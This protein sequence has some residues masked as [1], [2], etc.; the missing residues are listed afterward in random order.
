M[1]NYNG[2]VRTNYFKVKDSQKLKKFADD[3]GY[4]LWEREDGY[5]AFGE[6]DVSGIE[7]LEDEELKE[8]QDN[9]EDGQVVISMEIGNEKLR[10]LSAFATMISRDKIE[11]IDLFSH[12]VEVFSEEITDEANKQINY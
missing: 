6:Y 10:Y 3:Q 5:F 9:L 7:D 12:A 1:A 2:K 8:F 11:T 4:E